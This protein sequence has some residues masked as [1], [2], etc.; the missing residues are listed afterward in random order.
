VKNWTTF[1]WLLAAV[2]VWLLLQGS[3]AMQ[4][5][6]ASA[7]VTAVVYVYEKDQGSVPPPVLSAL[8]KLNRQGITATSFEDDSTDGTGDVPD[9]YKAALPAAREAGLPSL[10]VSAGER[11]LRTVKGPTTEEQVIESAK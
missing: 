10:V 7:K 6:G 11:V 1:D 9:Q 4:G 8:D 2:V 3:G 5:C